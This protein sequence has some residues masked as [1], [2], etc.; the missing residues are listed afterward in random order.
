MRAI[1]HA[2]ATLAATSLLTLVAVGCSE[3]SHPTT[4]TALAG[5]PGARF[6]QGN[7]NAGG[8]QN[9]QGGA[10]LV[11]LKDACDPA[12]F[13]VPPGPG[14]GTC[15]P[16]SGPTVTFANFIAEL[17]ATG[18]APQWAN[19]P[20]ALEAGPLSTITAVNRGGE[21]HTFTRVANFGGGIVP[22]LNALSNYPTV[23]PECGELENDDFVLPGGTYHATLHAHD[24]TVKFQCCI[25]PW[26]HTVVTVDQ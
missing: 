18:V 23:A 17:M 5:A 13:N 12:T 20:G 8:D 21:M 2:V 19:V 1:P 11:R 4:P 3:S 10:L 7:D 14:P 16:H 9:D 25:H 26:M 6:D 15:T 24:R 22:A